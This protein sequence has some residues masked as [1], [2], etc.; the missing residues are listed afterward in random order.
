MGVFVGLDRYQRRHR[1]LGLPLAVA[2]K[3]AEDQ[4]G[5]LAALI[6]FYGFVSLFPL[7]LLFTGGLGFV[8]RGDEELQ[9]QLL[10][11]ALNQ[12]PI[13]GEQIGANVHASNGSTLA[14]T[15]GLLGA[16]YGGLGVA[17][18]LQHALNVTWAI[19]RNRRPNPLI[20]RL[21]SL[22]L[23]V[24]GGLG[25]T[26]TT[27]LTGLSTGAGAY[28]HGPLA[29]FG[30]R[31]GATAAAVALNAA[32]FVVVF[33]LLTARHIA[34]SQLLP[35]AIAAGI[36]WQLLQTAGTYIVSHQLKGATGSYG[37]FGVVLG[38]L[39][40]LYVTAVLVVLCSEL[41]VVRAHSLWPRALLTPFTDNVDLTTADQRAY[42][43]YATAQ[44][45]KGF[46]RIDVG[47]DPEDPPSGVAAPGSE[48][49]A[50]NGQ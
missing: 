6:A 37:V 2:Y 9:R 20:S 44:R 29:G 38:L 48:L 10:D 23:L 35:G 13:V 33:R 4:G 46:Q 18:A 22:W 24:V 39:G 12:F 47:F 15:V 31:A 32:L 50:R 11:S 36:G 43:S 41:N 1:W 40:F 27:V 30:A 5:Y 16:L 34:L 14:L 26:A 19:P 28:T 45:H 49:T 42:A 17:Q 8:L 25:V 21:R 3:F 7:L